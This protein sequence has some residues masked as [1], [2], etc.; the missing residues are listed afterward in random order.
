MCSSRKIE[1]LEGERHVFFL[2]TSTDNIRRQGM[3]RT[4]GENK[5]KTSVRTPT[6]LTNK[7]EPSTKVTFTFPHTL[8]N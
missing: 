3:A 4:T 1:I 2:S 7:I 5:K 8:R 6:R